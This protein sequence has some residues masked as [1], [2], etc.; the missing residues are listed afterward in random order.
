MNIGS[1]AGV[2]RD[3]TSRPLVLGVADAP[4]L[5][6]RAVVLVHERDIATVKIRSPR[7]VLLGQMTAELGHEVGRRRSRRHSRSLG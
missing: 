4:R 2:H 6:R 1:R 7:Q 3:A 5:H